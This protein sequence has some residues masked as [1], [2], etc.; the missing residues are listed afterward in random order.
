M[1]LAPTE[2]QFREYLG[3]FYHIQKRS[4]DALRTW[5]AIADG[6]LRT[7]ENVARLAEIYNSFGYTDK[8]VIEISAACKLSPKD[9]SLHIQAAEYHNRANKYAEALAFVDI[10]E[11]LVANDDQRE[12]AI[13]QKI[14]IY[15]S[16]QQLSNIIETMSRD[17]SSKP[18][19]TAGEWYVLAR[20]QEAQREWTD[21]TGS[22]N[23]AIELARTLLW[24]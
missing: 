4:E 16:S 13:N 11:S 10:A 6:K 17:L 3:E 14:E 7:P 1:Q 24:H 20:F 9:F 2:P 19:S 15:Q 8:A 12:I 21:A 22:I 23:K 18:N 5:A